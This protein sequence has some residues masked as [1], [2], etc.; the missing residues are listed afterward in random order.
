MTGK[1]CERMA[2][3][4]GG[5]AGEESRLSLSRSG[6]DTVRVGLRGDWKL[7]G[8]LPSSNEVG[9]YLESAGPVSRLAV[10]GAEIGKWDSSLLAFLVGLQ[11]LCRGR[12]IRFEPEGLP[13]GVRRLLNLAFA[14]PERKGARRS[15]TRVDFLTM[16]GT[17][18]QGI[19]K[20]FG[21][22]LEFLG[23]SIRVFGRFFI[24]RARFRRSDL[25]DIIFE[26]GAAA[27]P[28][29]TLISFLVGL[30]LAFVGAIQLQQFGAE[31]YVANLVGIAMAREMGALMTAIIMAGRTGAAFAAQL[32]TMQVNEEIDALTTFGLASMEFLVLPRMIALIIMMPLLC[33]YADLMGILGGALVGVG[34]L[35]LS[36][37]EYVNQTL[38]GIALMDFAVGIV[39]SSVFGVLVAIAGCLRGIQCG[40]SASA[41]GLAATSAVV[42]GI[43]FIIVTDGI[44]AVITNV[45]GI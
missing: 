14:V 20:Q 43:V 3:P 10:D 44:F 5:M 38:N 24:G 25:V 12:S 16:I 40:R 2:A 7:E 8:G 6:S 45:L 23:E 11:N 18:T 34:M 22:M 39:K 17:E 15:E 19:W 1:V 41:V 30:I 13:E 33:I 37:T 32:G 29:C 28:I 35:G 36:V 31:I 4:G 27:L 21:Q 26:C 42:T 9:R